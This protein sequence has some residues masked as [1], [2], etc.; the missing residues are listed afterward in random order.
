MHN[1]GGSGHRA[2]PTPTGPRLAPTPILFAGCVVWLIAVMYAEIDLP[3][4][5]LLVASVA[6]LSRAAV[7]DLALQLLPNRLVVPALALALVA[8]VVEGS[9]VAAIVGGLLVAAPFLAIH[10]TDP[11]AMGFG[12]VKAAAAAGVVLGVVVPTV[13][14]LVGVIAVM[15]GTAVGRL[16]AGPGPRALGP[17]IVA[18]A[19]VAAAIGVA[20]QV[21]EVLP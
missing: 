21:V 10:L 18:G 13:G 20:L 16:R 11:A 15:I 12:D 19:G 9:P 14:P 6:A 7:H 2:S 4:T 17:T 1:R 3:T 8:G 5:V